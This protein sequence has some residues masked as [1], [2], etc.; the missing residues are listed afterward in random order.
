[1]NL[2]STAKESKRSKKKKSTGETPDDAGSKVSNV[3]IEKAESATGAVEADLRRS[4]DSVVTINRQAKP[5]E[6]EQVG[7]VYDRGWVGSS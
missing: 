3:F 6:E 2:G 5:Q 7:V 1:M 4:E